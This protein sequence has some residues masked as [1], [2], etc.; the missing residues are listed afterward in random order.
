MPGTTTKTT[1]P[2]EEA[3][4]DPSFLA[5]LLVM[6]DNHLLVEW[7]AY[8][9][10]TLPLRRLIVAVDPGSA[11]SPLPVLER[12]KGRINYTLW[13]DNDYV[14][15]KTLQNE[16]C[17]SKCQVEK[18][19]GITNKT[20]IELRSQ[21]E[22]W[23]GIYRLRQRMFLHACSKQLKKENRSWTMYIDTDEYL[24]VNKFPI[25][26]KHLKIPFLQMAPQREG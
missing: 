8:H 1:A 21:T 5:W 25:V 11:T 3:E 9:Y 23:H 14:D 7:L 16:G 15:D 22:H 10:T 18:R 4:E 24:V 12:W 2:N 17:Q 19:A 26:H 13:Y 6:D 20:V